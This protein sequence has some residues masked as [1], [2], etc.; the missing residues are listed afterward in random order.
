MYKKNLKKSYNIIYKM[1]SLITDHDMFEINFACGKSMK[2]IK[3]KKQFDMF[4]KLHYKKCKICDESV[5]RNIN[6][7]NRS[8]KYK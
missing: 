3:S 4:K 2:D 6:I 7:V 8:I 5:P 1:K